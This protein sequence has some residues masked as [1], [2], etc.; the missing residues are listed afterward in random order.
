MDRVSEFLL[1]AREGNVQGEPFGERCSTPDSWCC[2][3][4]DLVNAW[5]SASRHDCWRRMAMATDVAVWCSTLNMTS[6]VLSI[7][8]RWLC[9]DWVRAITSSAAETNEIQCAASGHPYCMLLTQL[10]YVAEI[11]WD[12]YMNWRSTG[13]SFFQFRSKAKP[14]L[15][16]SD[17]QTLNSHCY[18]C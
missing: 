14:K 18:N 4:V 13:T 11:T 7:V 3:Q 1:L 10:Q 9:D 6:R 17:C 16:V 12:V 5:I 2:R 8:Q 15:C